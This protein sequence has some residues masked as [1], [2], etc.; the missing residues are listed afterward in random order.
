M[1]HT[2][3]S[4]SVM[5]A[6]RFLSPM[7]IYQLRLCNKSL[8]DVAKTGALLSGEPID[9]FWE[10]APVTGD[11]FVIVSGAF[12]DSIFTWLNSIGY[13]LTNKDQNNMINV[14]GKFACTDVWLFQRQFYTVKV[15]LARDTAIEVIFNLPSSDLMNFLSH[16]FAYSLFPLSAYENKVGV[17]VTSALNHPEVSF[18]KRSFHAPEDDGK[19]NIAQSESTPAEPIVRFLLSIPTALEASAYQTAF[20]AEKVRWVGDGNCFCWPLPVEGPVNDFADLLP[21]NSWTSWFGENEFALEYNLVRST[22]LRC[23][24]IAVSE[25]NV[26]SKMFNNEEELDMEGIFLRLLEN[27]YRVK[28]A[29]RNRRIWDIVTYIFLTDENDDERRFSGYTACTIKM[30]L[31]DLTESYAVVR[32]R[33]PRIITEQF[34]NVKWLRF[35]IHLTANQGQQ[36]TAICDYNTLLLFLIKN[37]VIIRFEC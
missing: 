11:L 12:A 1:L 37:N 25:K 13:R 5:K 36:I 7:D 22:M 32:L 24:C 15:A 14:R 34:C 2:L 30:L 28:C 33:S 6:I 35:V 3:S 10:R 9:R 16:R 8:S 17:R 26:A 23:Y 19:P 4:A 29:R 27:P 31:Q 20:A 18:Q 21:F